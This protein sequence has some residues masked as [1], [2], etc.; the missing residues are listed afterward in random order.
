MSKGEKF[1]KSHSKKDEM[2][3]YGMKSK[4]KAS[5]KFMKK[6]SK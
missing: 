2:I 3:E 4:K 1:T 6:K 5:K